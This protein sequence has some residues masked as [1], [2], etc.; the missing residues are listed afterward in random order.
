MN[1]LGIE[2]LNVISEPM[3]AYVYHFH[4]QFQSG[5]EETIWP[6]DFPDC[7]KIVFVCDLGAGMG[8]AFL[9]AELIVYIIQL[10]TLDF[11]AMMALKKDHP[12]LTKEMVQVIKGLV[13]LTM[14]L[15]CGM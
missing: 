4:R 3:A 11:V 13:Q 6:Q 1:S 10:G 14:W 8:F 15:I 7:F 2:V 5:V 12:K 9:L